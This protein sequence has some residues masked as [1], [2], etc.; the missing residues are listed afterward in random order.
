MIFVDEHE[1]SESNPASYY[2]QNDPNWPWSTDDVESLD[3]PSSSSSSSNKGSSSSGLSDSELIA[4]I[5]VPVAI[6]FII[7]LCVCSR[8]CKSNKNAKAKVKP[9]SVMIKPDVAATTQKKPPTSVRVITGPACHVQPGTVRQQHP[10]VFS[11]SR[12]IGAPHHNRLPPLVLPPGYSAS[13]YG[14]PHGHMRFNQASP[15]YGPIAHDLPRPQYPPAPFGYVDPAY[16][17]MNSAKKGKAKNSE[18]NDDRADPVRAAPKQPRPTSSMHTTSLS[19]RHV[20]G[21]LSEPKPLKSGTTFGGSGGRAHMTEE[22]RFGLAKARLM[23]E[24]AHLPGPATYIPPSEWRQYKEHQ[25]QR[26]TCDID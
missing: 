6:V 3:T 14:Q 11:I 13:Q 26:R 16:P 21:L 9:T 10:P 25:Q 24:R 1:F 18:T 23:W 20:A 7:V 15:Q 22:Q 17:P 4:A 12:N 2:T 8:A 19:L 5:A